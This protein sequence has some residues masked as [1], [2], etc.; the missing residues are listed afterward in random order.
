MPAVRRSSLSNPAKRGRLLPVSGSG[1]RTGSA[2]AWAVALSCLFPGPALNAG[3]GP[4]N[5]LVILNEASTNSVMLGKAYA[6]Q[7]GIPERNLLRLSVT[8]ERNITAEGFSNQIRGPLL[9][10]LETSG[11]STQIDYL[12]FSRDFPYRIYT[13]PYTSSLHGGMTS[14]MFDDFHTS[15]N[16]FVF[17]CDLA[18]GSDNDYYEAEAAF[19]RPDAPV[20]PGY[21]IAALLAFTNQVEALAAVDRAAASDHTAPDATVYFEHGEDMLRNGR[22]L[23]YEEAAYGL[24]FVEGGPATAFPDGVGDATPRTNAIGFMTGLRTYPRFGIT[25]FVPGAFADHLTSFSGFLFNATEGEGYREPFQTKSTEWIRDGASGSYGLVVEPCAFPQ[26]FPDPRVHLWYGRGFSLGESVYLSVANPYQGIFI[27]DPLAQPYAVPPEVALHGVTENEEVSGNVLLSATGTVAGADGGVDRIDLYIDGVFHAVMGRR[28]PGALNVVTATVGGVTRSYTVQP[29]DTVADVASGLAA[30]LNANPPLVPV[31]A[32]ASGD[33]VMLRQKTLGESGTGIA[34]S[35]SATIGSATQLGVMAWAAGDA[36]ADSSFH[37]FATSQVFGTVASGDVFRVVVTTRDGLVVTN[38]VV[39]DTGWNA[40]TVMQELRAAVNSHPDLVGSNGVFAGRYASNPYAGNV[41]DLAFH[42]RTPGWSGATQSVTL[43]ETAVSA[44][45]FGGGLFNDN[46]NVLT[47]RGMIYL[48]AGSA[49]LGAAYTLAT[50]NLPDGPHELRVVAHRGDG[51]GSQGHLVRTIRVKNHDL[52]C[53]ITNLPGVFQV[54]E[55]DPVPVRGEAAFP[56]GTLTGILLRVEGKPAAWTNTA[57]FAFTVDSG[58]LGIGNATVQAQAFLDD[59]RT[60]L[61]DPVTLEVRTPQTFIS[62]TPTNG[63]V[64]PV[65]NTLPVAALVTG[66]FA[67]SNLSVVSGPAMLAGTNLTFTG[68]GEVAV[69][70]YQSGDRYWSAVGATSVITVLDVL[71]FSVVSAHGTVDPPP[72][73][74]PILEGAFLTNT[75]S[76]TEFVSGSTQWVSAGWLLLGD[77][78]FAASPTQVVVEVTNNATLTWR[79]TTNYWLE[80]SPGANGDIDPVS[81]WQPFGTSV[82]VTALADPYYGFEAW[83]G[84]LSGPVN[85]ESLAMTGPRS[86]GAA[87]TA[88]LTTNTGTP[89]WWLAS[90]GLTNDFAAEAVADQ[91]GDFVPAWEEYIAGTVPTN[92]Q[93]WLGLSGWA[94]DPGGG[95]MVFWRSETGRVYDLEVNAGFTGPVWTA[96]ATNLAAT[97]PTNSATPPEESLNDMFRVRARVAEQP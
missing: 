20:N 97:P 30:A 87:F 56:S 76:A 48:S 3:G 72:G 11:L 22:W 60:A 37:A 42:A 1:H 9:A 35:V 62:L 34:Y 5:A 16:A 90:F 13:G 21:R 47:A 89:E 84:D 95:V 19:R 28:D 92:D 94:P 65:T 54:H 32:S 26:K 74:Y 77:T 75:L 55:G 88:N 45:F 59:G 38:E 8:N 27:G 2:L 67:V 91:D 43:S 14:A 63:T 7:R 25:D 33:R 78:A 50:T 71:S 15:P 53:A 86:V 31:R 36:L 69:A 68:P 96:V 29:G 46:T 70:F 40:R 57:A 6:R 51:P 58:A 83:S 23:D 4:Q 44:N 18:A 85:P 61:S 81:G 64:I 41:A 39:A 17:G 52:T 80:T 93:S 73:M 24:R 82:T 66:G 49:E 79:W 10:Y 12:V